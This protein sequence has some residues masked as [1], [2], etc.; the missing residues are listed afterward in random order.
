ML[1]P[2]SASGRP[3]PSLAAL[4]PQV[5]H[6]VIALVF[7]GVSFRWLSIGVRWNWLSPAAMALIALATAASFV[8]VQSGN[9]AHSPVEA[10]PGARQ[11]VVDHE[12][13]G[14]WA[15]NA[16]LILLAAEVVTAAFV[17]R[18]ATWARAAQF[19]AAIVGLL[20]AGA[21]YR[22]GDLGGRLVYGYA[23]GVGIRSGD[24]ADVNR[25]L[26]AAAHHQANVDRQAGRA[27]DAAALIEIVA[28]RFPDHLELQLARAE[29]ILSDRKDAAAALARLDMLKVPTEDTRLRIRAGLLRAAA[30]NAAG[31]ASAARQVL[32]TLRSEFP[33]NARIQ[34]QLTEL[35]A[36][37]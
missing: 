15:R 24:P 30:L 8:A 10:V 7:V 22:A 1:G 20:A 36:G 3:M 17:A 11:A 27:A 9:D 2:D 37:R 16:I 26:I 13:W 12:A 21:V 29:A 25:T 6:F 32:E 18:N 34:Q 28:D 31:D 5:V 4:H 33:D 35:G 19:V 23:G 14:D